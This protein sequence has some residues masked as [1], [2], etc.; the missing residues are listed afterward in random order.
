LKGNDGTRYYELI[1][2]FLRNSVFSWAY[3]AL[4]R[5]GYCRILPPGDG[6]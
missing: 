3:P 6:R 4:K 5:P 2:S 1:E